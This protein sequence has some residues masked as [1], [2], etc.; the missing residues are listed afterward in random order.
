MVFL[1]LHVRVVSEALVRSSFL[2]HLQVSSMQYVGVI[3]LHLV[4]S[5]VTHVDA[6]CHVPM[7]HAQ[8]LILHVQQHLLEHQTSLLW[9]VRSL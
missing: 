7:L 6:L 1:Y 3:F 4:H 8:Q 5:L 9:S 2:L